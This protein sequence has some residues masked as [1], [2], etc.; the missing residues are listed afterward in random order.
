MRSAHSAI[1]AVLIV[2]YFAV[3]TVW[4][5]SALLRSPLLSGAARAVLDTATVVI[6]GI[7]FGI[8]VAGLRR[9]QNKGWI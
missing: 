7:F 5:P 2:V 4:L 9:A 6:W 1:K 3:A 8:G